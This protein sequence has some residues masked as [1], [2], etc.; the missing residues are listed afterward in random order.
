MEDQWTEA[1]YE[2]ALA[3][4]EALTDKLTALRT[5]IPSIISPLTRPATS[6]PAAFAGLKKAAIGAVTG[7]QD[8]RR[9]WESDGVQQLFKK[10]QTSYEK[11][12]N[13]KAAAEIPAWGWVK[14]EDKKDEDQDPGQQS[15]VVK[16]EGSGG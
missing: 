2:A 4:L 9:E 8:L 13:L 3:Q 5:T 1:Q 14:D 6:K 12:G 7:V 10:S 16:E 11:D 15:K